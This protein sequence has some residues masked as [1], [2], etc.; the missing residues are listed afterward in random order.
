MSQWI[1]SKQ[2]QNFWSNHSPSTLANFKRETLRRL[3][4]ADRPWLGIFAGV[5]RRREPEERERERV[6]VRVSVCERE[7]ERV[8]EK[9]RERKRERKSNK[10]LRLYEG[11]RS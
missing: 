5:D 4:S 1:D 3:L 7:S 11:E 9:E 6:C 2:Q 10:Y 8:R